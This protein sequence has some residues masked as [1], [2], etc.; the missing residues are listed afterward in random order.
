MLCWHLTG[1]NRKLWGS[2]HK[3]TAIEN[4]PEIAKVYQDFYPGDKVIVTDA[5]QYLLDHY[6]EFDFIWSSPPCPTHSRLA[7]STLKGNGISRYPDMK[8]YQEIIF[9]K[10]Y[11]KGSWVVENVIPFYVPLVEPYIKLCRHLFWCNFPIIYKKIKDGTKGLKNSKANEVKRYQKILKICLVGVKISG[12]NM[13]RTVLRNCVLPELGK[14]ILDCAMG[15]K[16]KTEEL[17]LF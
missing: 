11:F 6:K 8:L 14:H 10:Y 15:A 5:H 16:I 2:K 9:L 13:K 12:S 1:G 4:N 7:N 17:E 3:I